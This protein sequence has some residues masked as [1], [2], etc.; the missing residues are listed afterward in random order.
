MSKIKYF[1]L[2]AVLAVSFVSCTKSTVEPNSDTGIK[3]S[4]ASDT[5]ISVTRSA[6]SAPLANDFYVT[7]TNKSNGVEEY[8]GSVKSDLIVLKEGDY[9]VS[10]HS[11]TNPEFGLNTPYFKGNLDF[12]L[13]KMTVKNVE[14]PVSLHNAQV[15]VVLPEELTQHYLE[16]ALTV[17]VNGT[18]YPL[19]D[20]R[21]FY[22]AEGA[23][24]TITL[25]GKN[26]FGEVVSNTR[27]ITQS[28]VKKHSYS[29]NYKFNSALT[30]ELP[31]Q[32][33]GDVWATKIFINPVTDENISLVSSSE[34]M[35]KVDKPTVTSRLVYEVSS[36]GVNWIKANL[37]N[38]KILCEGL[39]PNTNYTLRA[40]YGLI[41]SNNTVSF[42]TENVQQLP[43]AGM[44]SW[45]NQ[46][47]DGLWIVVEKLIK[48]NT[49]NWI[50]NNDVA[51]ANRSGKIVMWKWKSVV[52]PTGD[53]V[54]GSNAV[55]ISTLGF[56]TE[57][58]L[59]PWYDSAGLK[60]SPNKITEYVKNKNR[61]V[62]G[63]L[64]ITKQA[65][66]SRPTSVSF[67]YKYSPY[68][69]DDKSE[70]Y[71]IVYDANNNII[72]QTGTHRGSAQA[73]YAKKTLSLNYTNTTTK[74]K[75]ITA[76]FKSGSK[77]GS[78]ASYYVQGGYKLN[79]NSNSYFQGS[80]LFID[81]IVL[82]Y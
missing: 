62:N 40:K 33:D 72:A 10:A 60:H 82:N 29:V 21:V 44:D 64:S 80:A 12:H 45:S 23:N 19:G 30:F 34:P 39:T 58:D 59:A 32:S 67:Q 68:P 52:E 2:L 49:T 70:I 18:D 74:A 75:Y 50:N 76:Y 3:I 25:A 16:F 15:D 78:S 47:L 43:N 8:S 51:L 54:S 6:I 46:D 48:Y 7:I 5:N 11:G 1:L 9:S 42:K 55:K 13:D 14:I 81:D 79:P 35:Q 38:A 20:S 37:K 36:D 27:Q 56:T 22:I 26:V 28:A 65:Q 69:S 31:A 63:V 17:N 77:T 66:N 53:K 24:A 61:T 73:N 57:A 4:F 41:Y 71:F